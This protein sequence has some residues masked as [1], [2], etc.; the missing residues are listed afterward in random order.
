[1]QKKT[2]AEC[3]LLA[4]QIFVALA[5]GHSVAQIARKLSLNE[6]HVR[7]LVRE[8]EAARNLALENGKKRQDWRRENV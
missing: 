3:E 1:M 8:N 5:K 2:K 7:E 6:G 4:P